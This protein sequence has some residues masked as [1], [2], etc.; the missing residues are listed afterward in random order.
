MVPTCPD[1]NL[2]SALILLLYARWNQHGRVSMRGGVFV[3]DKGE[4]LGLGLAGGMQS[5]GEARAALV[6]D[7][8]TFAKHRCRGSSTDGLAIERCC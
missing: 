7:D 4:D 5:D 2:Q 8:M 1:E 6:V 3:L